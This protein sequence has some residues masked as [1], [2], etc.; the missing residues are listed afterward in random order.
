MLGWGAGNHDRQGDP[1]AP[2]ADLVLTVNWD[3]TDGWSYGWDNESIPDGS[4]A[5]VALGVPADSDPAILA[6]VLEHVMDDEND[7]ARWEGA[8]RLYEAVLQI[9]QGDS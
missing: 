8:D 9:W 6:R 3:S 2:D 7:P 1:D 4:G 5:L